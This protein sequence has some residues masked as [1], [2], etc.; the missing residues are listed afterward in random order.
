MVKIGCV[1]KARL[2]ANVLFLRIQDRFE[3]SGPKY[4]STLMPYPSDIFSRNT[5]G[6]ASYVVNRR[7]KAVSFHRSINS[8]EKLAHPT[9]V[10]PRIVL[11]AGLVQDK[12]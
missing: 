12:S 5:N 8:L 11:T 7:Q 2:L 3:S 4:K 9:L 1:P 10:F 6:F